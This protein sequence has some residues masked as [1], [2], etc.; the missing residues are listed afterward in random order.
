M[1]EAAGLYD[2]AFGKKFSPAISKRADRIELF[3]STFDLSFCFCA[4][5]DSKLVGLAGFQTIEGSL[6]EGITFRTLISQLG[7]LRGIWAAAFLSL[8]DRKAST[9]ELVMDGISVTNEFRGKGIGTQ[10][11]D[12]LIKFAKNEGYQSLRLDVID[13][14]ERARKLYELKGFKPVKTEHF[15]YLRW[16]LGF[17]ASTT[18]KLTLY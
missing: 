17:G 10:L 4:F 18:M 1:E 15:E 16:L 5:V 9:K 2:E 11:L 6:T 14:N 12:D 8:Y 13:T 7:M 3:K